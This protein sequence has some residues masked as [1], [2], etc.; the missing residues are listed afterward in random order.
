M[1]RSL[2]SRL[3]YFQCSS[4]SHMSVKIICVLSFKNIIEK[5][6]SIFPVQKHAFSSLPEPLGSMTLFNPGFQD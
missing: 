2:Q 1:L 3:L 4:A 5:V 6:K